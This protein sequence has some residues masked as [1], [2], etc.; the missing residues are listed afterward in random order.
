M[1]GECGRNL[2]ICNSSLF[3]PGT[4]TSQTPPAPRFP[5]PSSPARQ[6]CNGPS[7]TSDRQTPANEVRSGTVS[8][9]N[10]SRFQPSVV[11]SQMR[12]RLGF[13]GSPGWP[14]STASRSG[15][16]RAPTRWS[17]SRRGTRT[18]T[19]TWAR[20]WSFLRRCSSSPGWKPCGCWRGGGGKGWPC[21]GNRG[22]L[23][24]KSNLL[25]LCRV[26]QLATVLL[27]KEVLQQLLKIWNVPTSRG[28]FVKAST[29]N[30]QKIY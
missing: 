30:C 1:S 23:C 29:L 26:L 8:H 2:W 11:I 15:P 17:W 7:T 28:T 22:R 24:Y 14:P 10:C 18:C 19:C 13:T 5:S 3:P 27:K 20:S 9:A 25:Q 6:R 16:R 12:T 21:D 4:S